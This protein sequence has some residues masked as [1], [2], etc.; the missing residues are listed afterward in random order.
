MMSDSSPLAVRKITGNRELAACLIQASTSSPLTSGRLRSSNTK[1]TASLP[2]RRRKSLAER[3][4]EHP[5]P[6]C[7]NHNRKSAAWSGSS[8]TQPIVHVTA[9]IVFFAPSTAWPPHAAAG[10][11]APVTATP[12]RCTN[13]SID[14]EVDAH[15]HPPFFHAAV[16][17]GG[18]LDVVDPGALD[19]LD[20]LAGLLQP[21]PHRIFDPLGGRCTQFDDLGDGHAGS[22]CRNPDDPSV[23]ILPN[24]DSFHLVVKRGTHGQSVAAVA[25]AAPGPRP[26]RCVSTATRALRPDRSWCRRPRARSRPTRQCPEC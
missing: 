14:F 24:R 11:Q 22:P 17:V 19:V 21:V 3:N 8:S 9:L 25:H 16:L 10:H 6:A 5:Y 1:S 13:L 23:H 12:L 4:T 15:V 7:S 20:G 2:R 26:A 18:N